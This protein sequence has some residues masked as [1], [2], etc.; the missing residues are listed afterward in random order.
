MRK[1]CAYQCNE[2]PQLRD[3]FYKQL[4]ESNTGSVSPKNVN[5]PLDKI[6]DSIVSNTSEKSVNAE[7]VAKEDIQFRRLSRIQE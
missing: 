6:V 1:V 3:L 2:I 4:N 7:P 5:K